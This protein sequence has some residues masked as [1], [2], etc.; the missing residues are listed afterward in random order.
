MKKELLIKYLNNKCTD[1]E[2]EELVSW[3]KSD[4]LNRKGKNWGFDDWKSFEPD[5]K[6]KDKKK[7]SALL[8]KIHHEINLKEWRNKKVFTIGDFSTW[9]S[10][11][12]AILFI[13]L[14]GV[15][16]YI[17]S[18]NNVQPGQFTGL[19]VDS[20]E[21]IAPIGSRTDVQLSDGTEVSLNY[22]SKIKYPRNFTGDTREITLV[23][24]GYFDVT[25][26]PDCPFIVK[27]GKINI[28]ALG[29][30]FNVHTYPGDD[31]IATTLVEGKVVI[32]KVIPDENTEL[33]GTLVPGQH[34]AYNRRS[35]EFQSSKGNVEKYIAWRE[36]KLIF[37]NEPITVVAEKLERMFNVDIVLA[38]N[39][40]DY[41]YTVTFMN[42]P[43]FQILDL[44]TNVTP[45]T[46]V[47]FPRKK[48]P[49]GTFSKQKIMIEKRK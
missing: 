12:A 19:A 6:N 34:V 39:V 26:N 29:T 2:F 10:R 30:K 36:G 31:V 11:V 23:G 20:I 22:G 3:L 49:D 47:A 40:T 43:L 33:L 1:R 18:F 8:D 46:Y 9:L 32:E 44:M 25:H 16:F 41:T 24:E 28:K 27:T 7:Y 35:D 38:D 15:V 14:L 48:L 21:I 37:D 45:V 17:L 4:A 13:P 5:F 42:D